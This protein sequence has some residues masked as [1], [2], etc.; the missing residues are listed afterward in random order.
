VQTSMRDERVIPMIFI[1]GI[2][3]GLLLSY[4]A[5]YTIAG[6]MI[7]AMLYVCLTQGGC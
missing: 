6:T 7:G 4:A 2:V 5:P 1:A 3:V